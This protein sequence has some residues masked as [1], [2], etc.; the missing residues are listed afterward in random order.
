MPILTTQSPRSLPR[1][2]VTFHAKSW[3]ND[4]TR[5]RSSK[6]MEI[7]RD[8]EIEE[9]GRLEWKDYMVEVGYYYCPI[10]YTIRIPVYGLYAVARIC[11][12]LCGNAGYK[13]AFKIHF[14]INNQLPAMPTSPLEHCS[15]ISIK[16]LVEVS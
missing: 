14:F 15:V 3:P 9:G 4:K 12:Y 16:T 11:D 7:K 6:I 5:T 8:E 13:C 1:I 2:K 10:L